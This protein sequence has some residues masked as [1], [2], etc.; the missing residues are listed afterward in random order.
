MKKWS[1]A[2]IA[3]IVLGGLGMY[4]TTDAQQSFQSCFP[5]ATC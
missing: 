2:I 3:A 4:V 1:L 5:G